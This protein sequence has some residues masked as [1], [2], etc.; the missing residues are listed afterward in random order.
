MENAIDTDRETYVYV[1]NNYGS[2]KKRHH[3]IRQRI[4]NSNGKLCVTSSTQTPTVCIFKAVALDPPRQ[5]PEHRNNQSDDT[6]TP[7]SGL[8][9]IDDAEDMSGGSSVTEHEETHDT[10][11][12]IPYLNGGADGMYTYPDMNRRQPVNTASVMGR[13]MNGMRRGVYHPYYPYYP[14]PFPFQPQQAFHPQ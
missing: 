7:T 5:T 3:R 11:K 13:N 10:H 14:P 1:T 2:S 8:M 12:Y 6:A 9:A 4:V